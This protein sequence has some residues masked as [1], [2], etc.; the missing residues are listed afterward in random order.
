[1][2][3]PPL[4]DAGPTLYL[5]DRAMRVMQW[6]ILA[7][8]LAEH[9]DFVAVPPECLPWAVRFPVIVGTIRAK[10]PD[11]LAVEELN[12]HAELAAA[13]PEY[14]SLFLEKTGGPAVAFG[15]PPD[16]TALFVRRDVFSIYASR[17]EGYGPP[18]PKCSQGFVLAALRCIAPCPDAGRVVIVGA[19]HLKAKH[20]FE[21]L[22]TAQVCALMSVAD[23]LKESDPALAGAGLVLLG[24]FNRLFLAR[25]Q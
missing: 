25:S 17:V 5:N 21:A 20:G 2:P 11:V 6:N 24:D 4:T 10:A 18:V 12:H 22:R 14:E 3:P 16:G 1:M 23:A 7:E 15:A 19:S 13:L 9:G 8:G